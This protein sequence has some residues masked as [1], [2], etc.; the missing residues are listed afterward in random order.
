MIQVRLGSIV[1]ESPATVF[2]NGVSP[3]IG[4]MTD[5]TIDPIT[6]EGYFTYSHW[7]VGD[8]NMPTDSIVWN[9][10][11]PSSADGPLYGCTGIPAENSVFTFTPG[12]VLGLSSA[13]LPAL[14]LGVYPNPTAQ[15]LMFRIPAQA[16]AT[17][18]CFN[19]MGERVFEVAVPAGTDRVELPSN[20]QPGSY[21]IQ[22]IIGSEVAQAKIVKL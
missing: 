20:L 2:Y 9:T 8:P 15:T 10:P 21:F 13:A 6:D 12:D 11:L 16:V 18:R 1:V 17:L 7:V 22:R 19:V 14:E 4:I 3:L 5:F